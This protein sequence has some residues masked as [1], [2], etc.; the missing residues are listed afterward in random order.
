VSPIEWVPGKRGKFFEMLW[1]YYPVN[2]LHFCGVLMLQKV[3][4]L[5]VTMLEILFYKRYT[6]S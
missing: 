3:T 1:K 2:C 4:L 5:E 6:S